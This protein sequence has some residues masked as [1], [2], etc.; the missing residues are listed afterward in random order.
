[1]RKP[2][3]KNLAINHFYSSRV[4]LYPSPASEVSSEGKKAGSFLPVFTDKK[5]SL[6]IDD[7]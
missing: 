7:I 2:D 5:S 6:G 1:M 4:V 3:K